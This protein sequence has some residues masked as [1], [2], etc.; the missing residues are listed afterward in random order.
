VPTAPHPFVIITGASRGIGAEYARAL[1][2]RGYDLLLIAR[3]YQRLD[4]LAAELSRHEVKVEIEALDLARPEAA[5][6][7]YAAARGR[8]EA[9][10]LLIHNAGFGLFGAFVEMPMARIQEMLRLHVNTVVEST[11]LFLPNMIDRGAGAIIVVASAAGL[12]SVPYYAEYAATKAFLIS[13]SEAIAEEVRP[14]GVRVQVCCPGSTSTDFHRTAG[15]RPNNPFGSLSPAQVVS[16]SLAA[17]HN[18]PVFVTVG[19]QGRILALAGRWLPKTALIKVA[20]RR[21]RPPGSET[22]SRV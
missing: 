14:S 17:L 1:A 6:R 2:G 10:D 5:Q 13:F 12:F 9:V 19:W 16:R 21:M 11:R 22:A 18:G 7:L 8:R 15:F 3:D 4:R 20:A